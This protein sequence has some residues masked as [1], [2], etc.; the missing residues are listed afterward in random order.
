MRTTS[1][2]AACKHGIGAS[3]RRS[4][5]LLQ[6]LG[7]GLLLLALLPPAIGQRVAE[8][9]N[10]AQQQA[11]E[12]QK[13]DYLIDT[14]AALKQASFIR[15]GQAYDASHAAAHMRLK[16]RFA[17]SRV[18]TAEEF[19]SYCATASSMSGI[20]YAIRFAD[21]HTMDSAAFLQQKLA[22]YPHATA[23]VSGSALNH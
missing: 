19:I 4:R 18:K 16:L 11:L 6:M 2:D 17:G 8:A 14:V 15:N 9:P 1:H 5:R 7:A 21:G 10:P 23:A 12:Q 3:E 22:E 20:R 13:I